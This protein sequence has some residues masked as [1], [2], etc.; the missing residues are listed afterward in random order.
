MHQGT[1]PCSNGAEHDHV[2]DVAHG[3]EPPGILRAE[4]DRK[5]HLR[6]LLASAEPEPSRELKSNGFH[7]VHSKDTLNGSKK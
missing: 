4:T 3:F 7:A 6:D 1:G 2:G 5:L